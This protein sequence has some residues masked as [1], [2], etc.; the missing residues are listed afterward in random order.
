MTATQTNH[1]STAAK[2]PLVIGQCD[3]HRQTYFMV[4]T[5]I[6]YTHYDVHRYNQL[7]ITNTYVRI[8]SLAIFQRDME[9]LVRTTDATIVY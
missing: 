6:L 2:S 4:C 3:C 1:T 7:P 5:Y 9:S 8:F